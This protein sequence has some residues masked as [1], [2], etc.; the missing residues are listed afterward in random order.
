ME[1][2]NPVKRTRRSGGSGEAGIL[3]D[4]EAYHRQIGVSDI[5][6]LI[7][8]QCNK[9]NVEPPIIEIRPHRKRQ[10][11]FAY[12]HKNRI[13]LNLPFCVGTLF[14]EL[15]HRI[16]YTKYGRAGMGHNYL[17]KQILSNI[18]RDNNI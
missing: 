18:L 4:Y 2:F 9:Y 17:F 16:S 10:W 1:S 15:A 8:P 6:N 14:H 13:A 3:V 11:G 12:Y 5:D 7:T